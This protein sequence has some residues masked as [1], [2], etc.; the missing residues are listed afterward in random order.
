MTKN[1]EAGITVKDL[2]Q[3][4]PIH[5]LEQ[6][7]E[8]TKVNK[9]VKKLTG[10]VMFQLLLMGV[11][12]SERL[13]LRIMEDLY[14]S[15]QFQLYAGLENGTTTKHTSLSDRLININVSFFEQMFHSVHNKLSTHFPAPVIKKHLI[16]RYD[17]TCISASAKLLQSGMFNGLPNKKSGEHT[18]RQI[19]ATIGFNGLYSQS[20]KIY[21]DQS[22]L[23]EDLALTEAIEQYKHTKDS[24]IVFD[25]GLKKRS[26]FA[27]FSKEGKAFVTRINP[28]KNYQTIKTL[29]QVDTLKTDTLSFISD[30]EVFL[31]HKDKRK[32]KVPFRLI[33]ACNTITEEE[34]FFLTNVYDLK[35]QDIALIYK[36][37]W[38]IEVFFRFLKQELNLKHF[39]SYSL[40]GIQVMIYMILIAAML[41]MI[42]K[43]LNNIS[44][45]KRAKLIFMEGLDTEIVRKIVELCGGDPE[46]TPLLKPT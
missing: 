45:Y 7:A 14:K 32:L 31:F 42:Y 18:M 40:N 46:K 36:S 3:L 20:L 24:I 41:I 33:K 38:E 9:N 2:L 17:S 34:L 1:K 13:S 30:Q 4:V 5:L 43:K 39:A 25:R 28:T 12:D 6:T 23:A 19:K 26:T 44:S 37:R 8:E 16:V 22:H 11:L 27:N 15:K 10:E 35:A 29:H 21:S